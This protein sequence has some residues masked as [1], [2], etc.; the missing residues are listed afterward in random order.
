MRIGAKGA[1]TS[2][3]EAGGQQPAAS[4]F[5]DAE[6]LE[7]AGWLIENATS[8]EQA[9]SNH[10]SRI[11]ILLD[12][13]WPKRLSALWSAGVRGRLSP[14]LRKFQLSSTVRKTAVSEIADRKSAVAERKWLELADE[15]TRPASPSIRDEGFK[16][17]YERLAHQIERE[18]GLVNQRLSWMMQFEGFLFAALGLVANAS[19]SSSLALKA[20]LV[21]VLPASG[22]CA[23][24]LSSFGVNAAYDRLDELKTM[25]MRVRGRQALVR[26]FGG[27]S[28]HVRGRVLGSLFPWLMAS[29]W[30]CTFILFVVGKNRP[31]LARWVAGEASGSADANSVD[32]H[33]NRVAAAS[34]GLET[35]GDLA[36]NG[37][38]VCEPDAGF[39]E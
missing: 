10:P 17:W 6:R 39:D 29:A 11:D 25:Y 7:L 4:I 1:M 21:I 31:D 32:P 8:I 35:P 3:V 23:A 15:L 19:V 20:T 12:R 2:D 36:T 24:L 22:I 26:P 18:D 13:P 5:T 28:A 14:F 16:E 30:A 27:R 38:L 37:T 9:L 33:V 34:T